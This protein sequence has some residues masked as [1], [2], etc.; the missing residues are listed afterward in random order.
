MRANTAAIAANTAA[1]AR[2]DEKD[3]TRDADRATFLR[4]T[5]VGLVVSLILIFAGALGSGAIHIA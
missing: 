2:R 4:R 3:A 5:A 1:I